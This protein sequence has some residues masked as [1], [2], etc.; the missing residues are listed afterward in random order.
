MEIS[1]VY[2]SETM[3][4]SDYIQKKLTEVKQCYA[5]EFSCAKPTDENVNWLKIGSK[6]GRGIQNIIYNGEV[7]ISGKSFPVAIKPIHILNIDELGFKRILREQDIN[8][9][10]NTLRNKQCSPNFIYLY[11]YFMCGTPENKIAEI[12]K[13]LNDEFEN[14]PVKPNRA[15]LPEYIYQ[16]KIQICN[17]DIKETLKNYHYDMYVLSEKADMSLETLINNKSLNPSELLNIYQQI[18]ISLE[19]AYVELGFIHNDL[20]TENILIKKIDNTKIKY[21]IYEITDP[22]GIY[23][24]VL[25][26]TGYIALVADFGESYTIKNASNISPKDHLIEYQEF[27][28]SD[29]LLY[30][31]T[32]EGIKSKLISHNLNVSTLP[33]NYKSI[34]YIFKYTSKLPLF[35]KRTDIITQTGGYDTSYKKYLKYKKKYKQIIAI[36]NLFTI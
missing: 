10:V 22:T 20:H 15:I 6:I 14:F 17:V 19:I 4:I 12:D 16:N 7:I 23:T 34:S 9:E 36:K 26:N 21:L 8:M 25:N 1:N 28:G 3:M 31:S 18:I 27:I 33:A 13:I 5:L 32:L 30:D 11:H 35:V 24:F 29:N 2:G